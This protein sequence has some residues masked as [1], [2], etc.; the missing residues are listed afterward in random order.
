MCDCEFTFFKASRP[1][2]I[3]ICKR[4]SEFFLK[5][6]LYF[7]VGLLWISGSEFERRFCAGNHRPALLIEELLLKPPVDWSRVCA[8]LH[9]HTNTPCCLEGEIESKGVKPHVR[10]GWRWKL[11]LS[12]KHELLEMNTSR[13]FLTDTS[14]NMR[15]QR[16]DINV[17]VTDHLIQSSWICAELKPKVNGLSTQAFSSRPNGNRM[18][19][20]TRLIF[21]Q[22]VT[23]CEWML[24]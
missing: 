12:H 9:I 14:K 5:E 2:I 21:K 23:K 24:L 7:Y 8:V 18:N 20:F 3:L 4:K 10:E 17:S 16:W 11:F 22:N 6:L 19:V 13:W 1:K 15:M